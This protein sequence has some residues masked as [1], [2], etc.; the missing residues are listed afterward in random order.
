MA[1]CYCENKECHQIFD[2]SAGLEKNPFDR[3]VLPCGHRLSRIIFSATALRDAFAA[4]EKLEDME[5]KAGNRRKMKMSTEQTEQWL[6]DLEA[7]AVEASL[8]EK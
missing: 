3:P 6:A 7:K 2:A 4:E 8:A 1:I 5:R